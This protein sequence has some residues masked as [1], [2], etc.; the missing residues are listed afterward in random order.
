MKK[1]IITLAALAMLGGGCATTGYLQAEQ[2]A[3]DSFDTMMTQF[4]KNWPYISGAIDGAY[5]G[6]VFDVPHGFVE[7]K[8]EI[9]S[10][11]AQE[12]HSKYD[13]GKIA[14]LWASIVTGEVLRWVKEFRPDIFA[15]IPT[16][17]VLL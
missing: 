12:Q 2:A 8:K 1:L 4:I 13:K 15:L 7:N 3:Y 5:E 16:G 6:K 17:M 10:I 11:V 9:D 14:T